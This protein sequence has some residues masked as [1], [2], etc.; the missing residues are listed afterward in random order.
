MRRAGTGILVLTISIGLLGGCTRKK[1]AARHSPASGEASA[2]LV[3]TPDTTPVEPL[4]TPAGLVL[5]A[6]PEA[7]PTPPA[8]SGTAPAPGKAA[9]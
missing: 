4:R 1:R 2:M 5:K 6:G 9:S 8:A 7:T 3:P